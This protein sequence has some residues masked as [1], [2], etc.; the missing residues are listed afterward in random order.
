MRSKFLILLISIFIAAP[1]WAQEV[2]H[3][4]ADR[5]NM[6]EHTKLKVSFDFENQTMPGEAWITLKPHFYPTDSLNLDAKSMLIHEVAMFKNGKNAALDYKY[7]DDILK[8]DLGKTFQKDEAYTIYIKYTA[9]PE[10]VK[11]LGGDAISD[12][13]GLYFINPTGENPNKPT[14]IWTQG[15]PESNSVWFPTLDKL[16]QKT[17]QEI[18]M[19]VPKKYVTLS[20]GVLVNQ[21]EN[22]DGTRTD[23][24]K[25][26]LKHAPYLFFMGVGDFAIIKDKWKNI[27]V[28]YY[29]EHEYAP[30]AQEIFGNTPEM[31]SFFSDILNYPYPWDKYSQMVVR[32]YVSGAMENTGAVVHLER[33]QQKHGQLVDENVWEDVIAHELIHH[34]FGDLVTAESWANLSM[35]EAFANYSEYLWREHKY[36]KASADEHRYEDLQSY[37][38]QQNFNKDLVR[39]NYKDV[40]EMFDHVTY[41]KG[42]YIL[43]ML[44]SYLGDKAFY[45]GLNKYLKDNE[46]GKAEAHQLRLALEEVSGRDLNWFFN[47]WFYGNGHPK[48]H[49]IVENSAQQVKVNIKQN[50]QPLFEFP[51]A[52]DVF[53][54]G[55]ATRH[56]VWVKKQS[57][58]TFNFKTNKTADLVVV[59]ADNDLIAEITQDFTTQQNAHRYAWSKDEYTNRML[60][61]QELSGEQL[62][63]DL[64][65]T[66][67]L[68][69]LDDP[70]DG[71]REQVLSSIEIANFKN[72]NAWIKKVEDLAKND[73]KTLVQAAALQSLISLKDPKYLSLYE[74]ALK[75]ESYAVQAAGLLGLM[76]VDEA[77]AFEASKH[78]EDEILVSAPELLYKLIPYWKSKNDT[79]HFMIMT[80][81]AAFYKFIALQDPEMAGTADE[82]F[83]WIMSTDSPQATAKTLQLQKQLYGQFKDTQPMAIPYLKSMVEDALRIK[84]EAAKANPSSSMEKQLEAIQETLRSMK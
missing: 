62:T 18:Y 45:A 80:E 31:I 5:I 50:Q 66:T 69:A 19:T 84:T 28:D 23:Y 14:Q 58:N 76:D 81:L 29:V 11:T 10:E 82:A 33:A 43:H 9:R 42:G 72:K 35:N 74:T 52:I 59:N 6:L 12:A 32:D 53:E 56:Q 7:A 57:V 54:N 37:F 16:N 73:P 61:L 24:W 30:Y 41:N 67:L 2:Y 39:F 13:K 49:V 8:I 15:E 20:N 51:L 21:T 60:A 34:W 27:P 4:E 1:F 38:A 46:F 70:Y 83:K 64:A 63:Q 17:S 40:Q 75:S 44:R 65:E 77:R 47:Q 3:P 79:S 22:S 68:S 25:Q 26:T 71:I 36:G 55:K 48:L 78:L